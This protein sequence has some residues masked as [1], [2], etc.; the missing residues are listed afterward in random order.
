MNQ[1]EIEAALGAPIMIPVATIRQYGA[2]AAL[3]LAY[4][5][6]EADAYGHIHR[7]TDEMIA[8]TGLSR[9][10]LERARRVLRDASK[11]TDT[12]VGNHGLVRVTLSASSL[13][14]KV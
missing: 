7:S 9:R 4:F 5:H 8:D 12:R 6:R 11:I 10:E 2:K 3:L 1:H 13:S 14:A